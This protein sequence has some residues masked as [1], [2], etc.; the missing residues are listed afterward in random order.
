MDVEWRDKLRKAARTDPSVQMA[1]YQIA[2]GVP[3]ADALACAV[4]VLVSVRENLEQ[5][6]ARRTEVHGAPAVSP[7]ITV[8][9]G[10]PCPECGYDGGGPHKHG[11]TK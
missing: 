5:A 1:L 3:E 2:N 4:L 8:P 9:E 6:L 10:V 11:F 7:F